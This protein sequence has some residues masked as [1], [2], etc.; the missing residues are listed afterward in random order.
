MSDFFS[1]E[2]TI[3]VH[4]P[5]Q[6]DSELPEDAELIRRLPMEMIRQ[7]GGELNLQSQK[8]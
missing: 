3:C 2:G 5:T 7:D 8:M 4:P 1:V 6:S